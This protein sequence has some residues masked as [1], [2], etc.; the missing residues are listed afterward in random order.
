[1]KFPEQEVVIKYGKLAVIII[2]FIIVIVL[3][4]KGFKSLKSFFSFGGD[5]RD[6]NPDFDST[7]YLEGLPISSDFSLE[8]YLVELHDSVTATLIFNQSIRC[9]A[10]KRFYNELNDNE[11][12]AVCNAYYDVYG[13]TLKSDINN[14]IVNGC[15]V[16]GTN[17][18]KR[19]IER[20]NK[21][22]IV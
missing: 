19:V 9:S 13:R 6:E 20:I 14:T 8:S 1:M 5:P 2:A 21:L 15:S 22:N 12:I 4:F 17:W 11:F 3:L 18:E 10:Y 7:E 16:F